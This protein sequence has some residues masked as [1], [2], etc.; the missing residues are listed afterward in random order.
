M[1]LNPDRPYMRA[2]P[3]MRYCI[4]ERGKFKAIDIVHGHCPLQPVRGPYPSFGI[5]EQDIWLELKL[6]EPPPEPYILEAATGLISELELTTFKGGQELAHFQSAITTPPALRPI[7]HIFHQFPMNTDH[8]ILR[9]RSHESATVPIFIWKQSA[10]PHYDRLRTFAFGLLFGLMGVMAIYNLFIY[11]SIGD[12]SYLYYSLYILSMSLFTLVATGYVLALW[13]TYFQW[14]GQKSAPALALIASC[15]ALFYARNFLLLAR[16]R[17]LLSRLFILL[18][19]VHGL[20]FCVLILVERSTAVLLGNAIP[21]LSIGIIPI[22]A[23]TR[24]RDGYRPASIF[25][26]AWALLLF[27]V[28]LFILQNLG[29]IPG[30]FFTQYL[31]Y[32][33]MAVEAILLSLALGYRINLLQ[34]REV[35][36]RQD[37]LRR[38]EEALR[39]EMDYGEAVARFVPRPFLQYL[40]KENILAVDKGQHIEKSMAV[41]FTDIRNFTTY[42][43]KLGSQRMFHFLN[44]FHDR[45]APIVEEEGGF[46]DKFIGDAI[47]A[48]FPESRQAVAAALRMAHI[49]QNIPDS[50]ETVVTGAGIHWGPL[51]LGT[52]GSAR[53]LETTVIGDT[54][55]LAA[56]VEGMNKV[57][58]TRLILS[59]SALRA[60]GLD[61]ADGIREIDAVRVKGK[62]TPVVLFELFSADPE[63]LREQKEAMRAEFHQALIAF[64]SGLFATARDEFG[65][66]SEKNPADTVVALYVRRLKEWGASAPSGWDGISETWS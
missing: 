15:A 25:L 28:A 21:A 23:I 32:P 43:E 47:M 17:P 51:V 60:A 20:S 45:M 11:M 65:R 50:D 2:G 48:L 64:K 53:R 49:A 34:Q 24:I 54:V 35:E 10:S 55:N 7:P 63:P 13:P 8:Y 4:A 37:L 29:V 33:A 30:N 5:T 66:L 44:I 58:G 27:G 39:R 19:S 31:Q 26:L 9:V 12:R 42:T 6:T 16:E 52:V 41:L 61:Q 36:A 57:Y 56:R 18:I 22:A 38:Q 14:P 59:D 62:K 40:G 46:I 1:K 3:A